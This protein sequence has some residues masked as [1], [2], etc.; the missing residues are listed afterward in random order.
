MIRDMET[1]RPWP[2]LGWCPISS[3]PATACR[4]VPVMVITMPC[5]RRG[6]PLLTPLASASSSLASLYH[7]RVGSL[8]RRIHGAHRQ[9]LPGWAAASRPVGRPEGTMG[10]IFLLERSLGG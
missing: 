10:A 6:G 8:L 9:D 2:R 1:R 5:G 3:P 7:L 4:P